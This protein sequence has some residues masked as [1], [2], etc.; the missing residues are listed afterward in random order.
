MCVCHCVCVC[1][2]VCVCNELQGEHVF[3]CASI[4]HNYHLLL[5]GSHY[6]V[7]HYTDFNL[8]CRKLSCRYVYTHQYI[9]TTTVINFSHTEFVESPSNVTVIAGSEEGAVF[10]CSHMSSNAFINWKIDNLTVN[11]VN[12]PDVT[13]RSSIENGVLVSLLM[14]PATLRYNGSQVVCVAFVNGNRMST[15]PATLTVIAGLF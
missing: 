3:V 13:D 4:Q 5:N 10:R 12:Y 9:T 1:V 6:E 11:S 7:H 2:C 14:V 15:P 8:P